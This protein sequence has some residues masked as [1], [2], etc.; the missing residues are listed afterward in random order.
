MCEEVGIRQW[1]VDVVRHFLGAFVAPGQWMVVRC[2]SMM[3]V[4]PMDVA[5]VVMDVGRTRWARHH[6]KR[7]ADRASGTEG[8]SALNDQ[9]ERGED[10]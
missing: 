4:T 6:G 5:M 1:Q 9:K 2:V 3:V 10:S 8:E 7:Q